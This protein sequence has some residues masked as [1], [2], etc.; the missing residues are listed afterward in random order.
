MFFP[1]FSK[2]FTDILKIYEQPKKY[3][4][5][6]K[7]FQILVLTI[8]IYQTNSIPQ[9]HLLLNYATTDFIENV[10]LGQGTFLALNFKKV[11]G[12]IFF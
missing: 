4:I 3:N 7:Y 9:L 6:P 10:P 8:I 5:I 1:L 11:L 12:R 2:F